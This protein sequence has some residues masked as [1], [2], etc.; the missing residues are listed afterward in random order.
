MGYNN[1]KGYDGEIEAADFFQTIYKDDRIVRF[2][3]QE[4]NKYSHSGDVGI[5]KIQKKGTTLLYA[6]RELED[7]PLN[8]CFIEVKNQAKPNIWKDLKKA[9]DDAENAGKPHVILYTIRH[10]KNKK[11]ERVIV[12]RPETFKYLIESGT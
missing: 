7:S 5:V 8:N 2:G 3:G 11:G 9:E 4:F 10:E 6:K 1:R 12:M